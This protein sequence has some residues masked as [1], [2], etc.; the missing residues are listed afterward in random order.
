MGARAAFEPIEEEAMHTLTLAALMIALVAV[1]GTTIAQDAPDTPYFVVEVQ[2]VEQNLVGLVPEGLRLDGHTRGAITEGLL[3][4]ATTTGIDY[5]LI[6]QDGVGVIDVRGFAQHPD[7]ATAAFAMRGYLGEPAPG[8]VEAMLDP[9]YVP[10][11]ADIPLHGA[12]WWETMAPQYAFL[13]HTVFGFTG[14]INLATGML[15]MTFRS[16]AP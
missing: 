2:L 15:R 16:L 7:G 10:P 8:V 12:S 6:R 3:A 11:D 5:L 4:G 14:T 1:P 9:E 13:N